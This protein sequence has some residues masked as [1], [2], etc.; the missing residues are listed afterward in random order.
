MHREILR[1]GTEQGNSMFP[2]LCFHNMRLKEGMNKSELSAYVMTYEIMHMPRSRGKVE[3]GI[4]QHSPF[5]LSGGC[6]VET[7]NPYIAQDEE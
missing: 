4:H 6:P 1:D 5:V 3:Q 2:R 7:R